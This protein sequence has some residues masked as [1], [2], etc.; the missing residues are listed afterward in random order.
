LEEI[1]R[2]ILAG[3]WKIVCLLGA[4]EMFE[5]VLG[6]ILATQPLNEFG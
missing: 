4:V 2:R 3:D 5:K 1:Q 6:K